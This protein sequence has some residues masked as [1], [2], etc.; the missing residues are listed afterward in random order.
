MG[1]HSG[2]GGGPHSPSGG[3]GSGGDVV[4]LRPAA[5]TGTSGK[6]GSSAT[7]APLHLRMVSDVEFVVYPFSLMFVDSAC[8]ADYLKC[9]ARRWPAHARRVALCLFLF[10]AISVAFDA[11]SLTNSA[12]EDAQRVHLLRVILT[13]VCLL[14]ALMLAAASRIASP[15]RPAPQLALTAMLTACGSLWAVACVYGN[16][17]LVSSG[18]ELRATN[19][20]VIA[21]KPRSRRVCALVRVPAAA[22][23]SE[24]H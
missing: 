10:L 13:A 15:Y 5:A 18:A 6:F 20:G 23:V 4:K 21:S 12:D 8:E 7:G 24:I 14:A 19:S 1:H 11:A 9:A 22:L 16:D 2:A 17:T 3:G